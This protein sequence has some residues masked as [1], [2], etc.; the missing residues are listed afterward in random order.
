MIIHLAIAFDQHYVQPF[1]AW[2]ASVI[3]HNANEDIQIHAISTGIPESDIQHIRMYVERSGGNIKFYTIDDV[4][5]DEFVMMSTWTKAVYFRLY[6]PLLVNPAIGRII[7]LDTD[8][9]VLANLREL[10]V[11][12]LE[13][14]PVGAVY[15]NYVGIQ[16]LIGI[17][18]EGEYFNSG[19]LVIDV[20]NWRSLC[21]SEKTITYLLQYPERIKFVDQCGLNAVLHRNWKR[22]DEK[23]NL[24]FSLIPQ[25]LTKGDRKKFIADKVILHFTLQRPWLMLCKNRFR[26]L[27]HYY[28]QKSGL[29]QGFG[30]SDFSI[31]KIPAWC[32]IRLQEFYL[33]QPLLQNVWHSIKRS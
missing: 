14:Y 16:P 27:Y 29:Y 4:R 25:N 19:M 28:L 8:T 30:I 2:L 32:T 24:I 7:Y 21:V 22:L 9:L 5:V 20:L 23:F 17:V 18:K 10:Y 1:Y 11:V 13:G 3:A 6:F 33:D 12:D 15:D 26:Y 31:R